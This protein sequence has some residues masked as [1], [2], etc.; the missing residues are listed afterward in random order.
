[1]TKN[2][3]L[4]S[5][6]LLIASVFFVINDGIIN[7][8]SSIDIKFYHFIFYGSPAYFIV[9]L[10]LFFTGNFKKHIVSTNYYVVFF[11][12]ITFAPMPFI[13]FISLENITLPEFTTLNMSSPMIAAIFAYIFLKEKL[14]IY[15]YLSLLI[16]FSGVLFVIQPGFDTFNK[17]YLVTLFG[18]IL[19]TSTTTIVNRFNNVITAIGYFIYGGLI[20]HLISFILFIYDPLEVSMNVFI[21][22]TIASVFINSAIFL[23][24]F[25]FKVAQ[26]YYASI[27]CL[28]YLQIVWSCLIGFYFFNEY[29]N[30]F[31]LLGALLIILSGLISI[32]G[33]IRQINEK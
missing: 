20:I 2:V 18:V 3:L 12:S 28:V 24:T 19:I 7:Y 17:Y 30:K 13:T 11:R 6:C 22:I 32:P 1:M 15:I 10:Y 25:A 29:L 8:L 16:G 26:K 9:P 5:S 21:F 27:F 33:Q 4:A 14:N 23:S 31:A